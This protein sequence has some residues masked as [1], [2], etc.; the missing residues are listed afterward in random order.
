MYVHVRNLVAFRKMKSIEDPRIG[1]VHSWA[2]SVYSRY[3]LLESYEF[4]EVEV[5]SK[6]LGTKMGILKNVISQKCFTTVFRRT[7]RKKDQEN[8]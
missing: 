6:R 2:T 7:C 5:S 3:V 8:P 1:L 4:L